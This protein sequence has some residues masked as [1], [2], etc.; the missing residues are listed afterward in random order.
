VPGQLPSQGA[1]Q[2]WKE[3]NMF[4]V[5]SAKRTDRL[6]I[7]H[8]LEL[9]MHDMSEFWDM[10]LDCHGLFGSCLDKYWIEPQCKPFIFFVNEHPAGFALVDD[11]VNLRENDISIS[12][13]FVV[14]KHRRKGFAESAARTIF[15]SVRGKWE[16]CQV[17]RNLPAQEFWRKVIARY[18]GGNF[19]EQNLNDECWQG[20]LQCFDN[21]QN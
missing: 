6:P 4:D 12:Q 20:P 7:Q 5:R 10:E 14:R 19:V 9:Y 18:T 13:F 17:S 2:L 21:S 8:M 3:K 16:I 15:D 11:H 1:A